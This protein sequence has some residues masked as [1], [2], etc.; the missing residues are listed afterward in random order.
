MAGPIS[1]FAGEPQR[2]TA[3]G[4]GL[5]KALAGGSQKVLPEGMNVELDPQTAIGTVCEPADGGHGLLACGVD[6]HPAAVAALIEQIFDRAIQQLAELRRAGGLLQVPEERC[7]AA[8]ESLQLQSGGEGT[9]H[10]GRGGAPAPELIGAL[11]LEAE[12]PQ[13]GETGTVE[14]G[15][16]SEPAGGAAGPL[17]GFPEQGT[18]D[19]AAT[20]RGNGGSDRH[21]QMLDLPAAAAAIQPAADDQAEDAVLPTGQ[22]LQ[23]H[24]GLGG[25]RLTSLQSGQQPIGDRKQKGPLQQW[26]ERQEGGIVEK[27]EVPALKGLHPEGGEREGV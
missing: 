21:P 23:S 25:E 19:L 18:G 11:R 14:T 8:M 26:L 17:D 2:R 13:Q 27:G 16:G 10:K 7:R 12:L 15:G 9:R 5:Q 3:R 20:G 6:E 24:Q 22:E 4:Q 1:H